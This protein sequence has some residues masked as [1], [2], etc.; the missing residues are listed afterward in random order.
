MGASDVYTHRNQKMTLQHFR[1]VTSDVD[2]GQLRR[3]MTVALASEIPRDPEG[4]RRF[5]S[6]VIDALDE[7]V[8][9]TSTISVSP[10]PVS[11]THLTLPTKRIG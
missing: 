9:E 5:Y 3:A 8:S 2:E 7:P 10:Q 4:Y 11:Y 6:R 1:T